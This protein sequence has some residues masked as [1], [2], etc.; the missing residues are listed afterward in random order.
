MKA[1]V[2]EGPNNLSLREVPVPALKEG[3][4]LIRV[5]AAAICATD[6]EVIRG[7]IPARYP[8]IPGHEWSG[9]VEKVADEADKHW[10]G[11]RVVGSNDICCLKCGACRSGLWRNCASFREIG[12]KE[13]GAYAEYMAV[14]VYALYELPETISF[15]Q[16]SLIEPLG[17]AVGTLEKTGA[18][19]GETLL[20]F[21]AGSIGLNILA[22]AKAMGMRRIIVA[23]NSKSSFDIAVKMGAYAVAVTNEVDIKD[24]VRKHH[25][26]GTDV[27]IDATG[28][29]GCIRAALSI[30]KRGGKVGLTGYG[31]GAMMNIRVDDIH[32][33]NLRVAGAGNNWNMIRKCLNLLEDTLADISMLATN[34]IKLE[35][36]ANGLK[37]AEERPRGFVKAVF[38]KI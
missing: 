1:I 27:V 21:G 18:A 4:A 37:M 22:V 31:G 2:V 20:I 36:Y 35:D 16:G 24:F 32:I 6:L 25:P 17:V 33:E 29:E 12:F 34:L 28:S 9:V 3:W 38:T 14:P 23:A 30:A 26:D 19:F 5:E 10:I 11:K 7:R 8:I 13:D 15:I